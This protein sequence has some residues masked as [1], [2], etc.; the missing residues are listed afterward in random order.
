MYLHV[1]ILKKSEISME[2]RFKKTHTSNTQN[3]LVLLRVYTKM[4]PA[5][6]Y[7]KHY[8]PSKEEKKEGAFNLTIEQQQMHC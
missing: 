3:K 6:G 7:P 8:L 4:N 1:G 5:V 2:N